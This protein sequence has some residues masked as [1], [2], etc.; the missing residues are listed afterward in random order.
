MM[1]LE[2]MEDLVN[3]KP[4]TSKFSIKKAVSCY[5]LELSKEWFWEQFLYYFFPALKV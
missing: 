1:Q 4:L 2:I 5:I 3:F